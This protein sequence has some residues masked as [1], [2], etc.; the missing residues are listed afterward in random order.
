MTKSMYHAAK[1]YQKRGFIITPLQSPIPDKPIKT[2][3]KAE[4][5]RLGKKPLMP[6]FNKRKRKF[7]RKELKKWFL[8]TDNNIGILTGK[9]NGIIILDFDDIKAKKELFKGIKIKTREDYRIKGRKHVW[10][11]YT[12]KLSQSRTGE[13]KGYKFEVSSNRKQVVVPPSIHREGQQYV[14]VDDSVEVLEMPKKLIRRILRHIGAKENRKYT[15]TNKYDKLSSRASERAINDKIKVMSDKKKLERLNKII[16]TTGCRMW[17]QFIWADRA[18]VVIHIPNDK[19]T[20]NIMLKIGS[21]LKRNGAVELDMQM[22][23]KVML[24]DSYDEKYTSM[25][26]SHINPLLTS[27]NESLLQFPSRLKKYVKY[28]NIR[29]IK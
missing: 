8:K 23:C 20:E 7:P 28:I 17:L 13:I 18:N 22:F 10:F 3:S 24:K 11:R 21:E 25:K 29:R 26:W 19:T 9:R 1:E 2:M 12:P 14:W 15:T 5:G 16:Y 27:T 4:I 6:K